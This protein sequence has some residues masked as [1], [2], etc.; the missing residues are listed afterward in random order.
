MTFGKSK[1]L[2][3]LIGT[4]IH[5]QSLFSQ[6]DTN[7]VCTPKHVLSYLYEQ[8]A[9]SNKLAHDTVH[10][11]SIINDKDKQIVQLDSLVSNRDKQIAVEKSKTEISEIEK[12]SILESNKKISRKNSAISII[13]ILS[14]VLKSIGIGYLLTR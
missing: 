13:A 1:V 7:S 2:A 6:C 9:K 11:R 4:T 14:N 3:I 10:L 12:S 8:N 5:C